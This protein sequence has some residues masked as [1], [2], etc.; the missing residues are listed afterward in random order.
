MEA[1][2]Q[3]IRLQDLEDTLEEFPQ[4]IKDIYSRTWERVLAQ[5]PKYVKLA[6][7]VFLW[8]LYAGQELKIDELRRAVAIN[9]KDY[10]P[11]SKRMVPEALLVSVC[12][13]LVALDPKSRIV[14]LI[15][16][17]QPVSSKQVVG[18]KP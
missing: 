3:C 6:E 14:R 10:A 4:D 9:P 11:E 18:L 2:R 1:L 15:R 5:P 8:I 17:S 12:C 13:G 16:A 7:L